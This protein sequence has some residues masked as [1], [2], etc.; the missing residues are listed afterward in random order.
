MAGIIA[1]LELAA[2]DL[3]RFAEF[4]IVLVKPALAG[5]REIAAKL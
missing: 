3:E 2:A 1:M 5:L 4:E